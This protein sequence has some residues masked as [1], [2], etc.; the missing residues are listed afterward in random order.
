[1]PLP[2]TPVNKSTRPVPPNAP[3]RPVTYT[4]VIQLS[5]SVVRQLN[6]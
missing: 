6:F 5:N 4:H 3:I 2:T 1:M